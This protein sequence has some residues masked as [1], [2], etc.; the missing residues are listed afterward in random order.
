[1]FADWLNTHPKSRLAR[2]LKV[3]LLSR[4][5]EL[6]A[7][8]DTKE[9]SPGIPSET[10]CCEKCG[11]PCSVYG[12]RLICNVCGWRGTRTLPSGPSS[13]TGYRPIATLLKRRS[14]ATA[15]PDIGVLTRPFNL[16]FRLQQLIA[17]GGEYRFVACSM[18][19]Q[20][21]ALMLLLQ[22]AIAR[23]L[24]RVRQCAQCYRWLFARRGIQKFC[25][26]DCQRK[27][28]KS[29]ESWKVKRKLYMRQ[30]RADQGERD[31]RARGQAKSVRK[32]RQP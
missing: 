28:F 18:H 23:Q 2:Y 14:K 15:G 17:P 16:R 22:L 21:S 5:V 30:Y 13:P 4:N 3:F 8:P 20:D 27:F 7:R 1:M 29:T 25:S 26:V 32:E 19:D 12:E 9:S 24:H 31:R 10:P 11:R 6:E